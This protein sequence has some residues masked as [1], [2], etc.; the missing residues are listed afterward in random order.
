MSATRKLHA[1][2]PLSI[3]AFSRLKI[4]FVCDFLDILIES[5]YNG[6]TRP[7]SLSADV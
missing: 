2:G 7:F 3:F 6:Q 4:M 5:N 1:E